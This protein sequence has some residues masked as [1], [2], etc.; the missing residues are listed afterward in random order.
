MCVYNGDSCGCANGVNCGCD[1]N[2][3]IFV[4]VEDPAEVKFIQEEICWEIQRENAEEED[5]F[6]I[7]TLF[8]TWSA[9]DA[10]EVSSSLEREQT[11]TRFFRTG[12]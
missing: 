9:V 8:D 7:A 5:L 4:G 6:H 1:C 10:L 11:I 12:S 2:D 3:C